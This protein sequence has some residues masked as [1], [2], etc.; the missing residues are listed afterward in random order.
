MIGR[1]LDF[2]DDYSIGNFLPWPGIH[3]ITQILLASCRSGMFFKLETTTL[4]V[5]RPFSPKI[6]IRETLQRDCS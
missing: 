3:D 1:D 6:A 4:K 2:D 5:L